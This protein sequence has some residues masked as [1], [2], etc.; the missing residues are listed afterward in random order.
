LHSTKIQIQTILAPIAPTAHETPE[1]LYFRLLD[2][3]NQNANH[4]AT[5][6]DMV[7]TQFPYLFALAAVGLMLGIVWTLLWSSNVFAKI[8]SRLLS[9]M[10][11]PDNESLKIDSIGFATLGG[12]LFFRR[13]EYRTKDACVMVL[14]ATVTLAWWET[15]V[16]DGKRINQS[17]TWSSLAICFSN[18]KDLF[19]HVFQLNCPSDSCSSSSV[20]KSWSTITVLALSNC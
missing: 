13:V 15:D 5:Q 3:L 1:P 11:L 14:Q 19:L 10:V 4:R 18:F 6:I 20:L 12:Q 2:I 17:A 8:V 9:W 16:R 7:D